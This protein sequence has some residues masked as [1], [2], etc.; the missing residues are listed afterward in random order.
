MSGWKRSVAILSVA[1]TFVATSIVVSAVPAMAQDRAAAVAS[2]TS[3]PE[4][5]ASVGVGTNVGTNL[6]FQ[7][8]GRKSHGGST[9]DIWWGFDYSPADNHLRGW[10]EMDGNNSSIHLQAEPLN[11]GDRNGL[12]ES[13]NANAQTGQLI[14]ETDAVSC[15]F[16][17]GIYRS[18]LHYSIRW[19]DGSLLS[20]Q[21]T[22]QFEMSAS[23]ICT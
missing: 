16:P 23:V 18:N 10:A 9:V 3:S 15:H 11:L 17:N 22:G 21:Q 20:G 5:R 2:I 14:V 4:S 7:Y 1:V 12:L 19:P 6:T 13:T 8:L